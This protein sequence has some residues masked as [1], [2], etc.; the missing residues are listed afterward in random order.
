M[1]KAGN[2]EEQIWE[3]LGILQEECAEAIVEV[4]KCRRFGL[5]S[6]HYKSGVRHN[7]MLEIELGDVLAMIDI[8]VEQ[9]VIDRDGLELA[10]EE[11]KNKLQEWSSIYKKTV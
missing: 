3:A 10:A 5:D 9:G 11:K 8:L 2:S 4:S 6:V 1:I 7:T